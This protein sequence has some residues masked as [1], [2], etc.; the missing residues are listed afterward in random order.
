M[1]HSL[2][3]LLTCK[4][5]HFLATR[6]GP[7]SLRAKAFDAMYDNGTWRS[8]G[9]TKGEL[10]ATI[11][12]HLGDGNLLLL[13][14]GE[15]RVL[16]GLPDER[17]QRVVGIDLSPAAI[18]LAQSHANERIRFAVADMVAFE[19]PFVG[20]ARHLIGFGA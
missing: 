12:R 17:L 1:L 20:A 16:E 7:R 15:A 9:D 18:G 11:L 5:V 8:V 4:G 19:C 6:F 10:P 2:R 3:F 13:G 14:C